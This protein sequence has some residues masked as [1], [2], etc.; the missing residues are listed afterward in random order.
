M[1]K[2]EVTVQINVETFVSDDT[3][4]EV[5]ERHITGDPLR[6]LEDEG[7]DGANVAVEE[8]T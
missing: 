1:K 5:L 7:F 3:D 6:F 2:I 8:A 4:L